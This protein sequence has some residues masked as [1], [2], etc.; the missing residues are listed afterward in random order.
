MQHGQQI[1]YSQGQIDQQEFLAPI[2]QGPEEQQG[3]ES[4]Q[5]PALPGAENQGGLREAARVQYVPGQV[6]AELILFLHLFLPSC[7]FVCLGVSSCP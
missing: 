2:E 3:D 5:C 6:A 7:V 1:E 4:Q